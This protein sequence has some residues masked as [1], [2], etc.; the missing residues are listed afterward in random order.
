MVRDVTR[1]MGAPE[2]GLML[3]GY[4]YGADI[5]LENIVALAEAMEDYCF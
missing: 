5:P 3:V 1:Q 2:G 4:I